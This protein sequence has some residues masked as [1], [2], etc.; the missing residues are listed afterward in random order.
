MGF[1]EWFDLKIL[2][3]VYGIAELDT[4]CV[5]ICWCQGN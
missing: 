5:A 1:Y 3:K 2:K 4:F